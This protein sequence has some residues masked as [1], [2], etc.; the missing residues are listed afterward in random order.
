MLSVISDEAIKAQFCKGKYLANNVN[1]TTKEAFFIRLL[2]SCNTALFSFGYTDYKWNCNWYEFN[3]LDHLVRKENQFYTRKGLLASR[4]L[5]SASATTSQ[6]VRELIL[7]SPAG[8]HQPAVLLQPQSCLH[9]EEPSTHFEISWRLLSMA[10]FWRWCCLSS[11]DGQPSLPSASA[12]RSSQ[13]VIQKWSKPHLR[14]LTVPLL[15]SG[16]KFPRFWSESWQNA[17]G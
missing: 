6:R 7:G 17:G 3:I 2:I 1:S 12:Y 16:V 13:G 14:W 11:S 10:L 4:V 9:F 5:A 8:R 15:C